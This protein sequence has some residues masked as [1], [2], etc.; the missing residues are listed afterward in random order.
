MN[1]HEDSGMCI[2]YLVGE[3]PDKGRG[4]FADAAIPEGTTVWRHVAGCFKV[5]DEQALKFLLSTLSI[6]EAVYVLTHIHCMPEYPQYMIRVLDDG[7][8]TNHSDRPTL[9]THSRPGYQ[10]VPPSSPP[11]AVA[12]ALLGDHFTL[13]AARDIGKGEELTLDYNAD[14]DDPEYYAALCE[15]YG[16]AWDW[17]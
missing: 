2:P 4:L 11:Q 15:H 16:V 9:R 6:K 13:V 7:E 8:L 1:S 10:K 5:Y 3:T 14:P 17:L 12:D